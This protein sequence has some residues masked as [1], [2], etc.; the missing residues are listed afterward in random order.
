MPQFGTGNVSSL[1]YE[2]NVGFWAWSNEFGGTEPRYWE[3]DHPGDPTSITV[4]VSALPTDEATLA[5]AALELWHEVA[6]ITF[7]YTTGAADITYT[8]T[9]ATAHTSQVTFYDALAEKRWITGAT[10]NVPRDW[11]TSVGGGVA[12]G[13]NSG[14]FETLIHETGHALGLGHSGNYDGGGAQNA[15]YNTNSTIYAND[16]TQW[17]IMSYND[18]TQYGGATLENVVTPEIADIYAIQSTYG[19]ATTTR[20]GDT[21]Y[22]FHSN[23]GPNFD[24][25]SSGL[26]G[27]PSMT[28][29]DTGGYDTLDCSGFKMAQTIDLRSGNFSSIGGGINN[30]CIYTTTVIE[31]AAGGSGND[32]IYGSD[33]NLIYAGDGNDK[34]MVGTGDNVLDGDGGWDR[35]VYSIASNQATM[36]HNADGTWTIMH[37]G[38]PDTLRNIEVAQFSD[39]SVAL[40]EAARS[41]FIGDGTSST[42]LIS[43]GS[44]I[45]WSMSN[46]SFSGY[47][48][49]GSAGAY[50]VLGTG[51][52][53]GDGTADILLQ[54]GGGS[55]IDWTISNGS[56]AGYTSIGNASTSGY[57]FVGTGD[58]NGDGT[59][60]ILLENS[61]GALI[62]WTVSNGAYSSYKSIGNTSGYGVVGTGDF[63]ADATTDVL[64][65][66]AA[67]SVIDWILQN[68]QYAS[69]NA[70]GNANASGYG[71]VRTGDFNGD[72]ATDILLQNGAGNLI[73]WTMQNGHYSGWNEVGNAAGYAV[74]GIGDYNGDGTQ[75]IM[76]QS[77]S[78]VIDWTLSNGTFS[79]WH[80]VGNAGGYSVKA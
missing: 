57:G 27:A 30:I 16:T 68:G 76:L 39:R 18:Q 46:G 13:L 45:D 23:A 53:N 4:N 11:T 75:D 22:G 25:S 72:G 10:V 42:L 15:Y 70:I 73:D 19:A 58:V 28:I 60:D 14:Y 33:S 55:M 59:S 32:T 51:D 71:I 40:H 5:K 63:N 56:Y 48:S 77:G 6:N 62:D 38:V 31:S 78:T 64:M 20:S 49:I 21:I 1:A 44:V 79:S 50:G 80:S 41:D 26:N 8:D 9:D 61:G 69:Y 36:T 17:S 66:N 37:G 74:V 52:F 29:Y 7:T 47:K 43:G 54:N 34:I 67:G 65:Q 2:I 35:A 3:N 24:I 12:A